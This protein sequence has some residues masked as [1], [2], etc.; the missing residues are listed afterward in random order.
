MAYDDTLLTIDIKSTLDQLLGQLEN[1]E[2][3]QLP[4][5][6]A[7][8]LFGVSLDARAEMVRQL[9]RKFTIRTGEKPW[10]ARALYSYPK[11]AGLIKK[12]ITSGQ[13]A[14][15]T[16]ATMDNLGRL[17]TEGG[18]KEHAKGKDLGVPV[19]GGGR[20]TPQSLVRG[21][22]LPVSVLK[23]KNAFQLKSSRG[24]SILFVRKGKYV[25][26]ENDRDKLQ[27]MFYMKRRVR[28]KPW[29]DLRALLATAMQQW[30]PKRFEE[31][32]KKAMETRWK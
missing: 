4:Y 32:C 20:A 6:T 5:A 16:V 21:K 22:K 15:V 7:A 31:A 3:D 25:P 26:G 13:G 30:F 14:Y 27:A 28:V 8:A 29:W 12:N 24:G 18:V 11:N 1:F 17:L 23:Q 9:P 19:L 10:A 2:T